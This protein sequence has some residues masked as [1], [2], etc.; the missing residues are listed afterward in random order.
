MAQV[1]LYQ[2]AEIQMGDGNVFTIGSKANPTRISLTGTG[3]MV[4]RVWN[5]V[6]A[7]TA[8][9][10]AE[11]V[12]LAAGAHLNDY[13]LLAIKCSKDAIVAWTSAT[14]ADTSSVGVES[15]SWLFFTSNQST[16][17]GIAAVGRCAATARDIIELAIYPSA[18]ADVELI[19]LK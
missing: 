17:S 13:V 18:T 10:L 5:D 14:S 8:L 15:N 9:S 7:L 19:I 16:D 1:N 6:T 2:F 12:D 3:A 4:R 11:D